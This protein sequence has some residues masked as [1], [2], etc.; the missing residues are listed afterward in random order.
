MMNGPEWIILKDIWKFPQLWFEHFSKKN[1]NLLKTRRDFL[2]RF[3]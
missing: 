2:E 1:M 3:G